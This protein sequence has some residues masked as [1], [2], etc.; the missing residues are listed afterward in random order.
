M[1]AYFVYILASKKGGVLYT[2][3]TNSLVRRVYEHRKEIREGFTKKYFIKKLVYFEEYQYVNEAI[4]REKCIKRWK[5]GWKIKL[6]ESM[7][8]KWKD[9]FKEIGGYESIPYLEAY[10]KNKNSGVI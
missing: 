1:A 4:H 2:G 8:P 6:I 9:L 7:N 5:R 10:F 3:V